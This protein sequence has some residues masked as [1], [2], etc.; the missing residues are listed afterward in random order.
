MS[1]FST[2]RFKCLSAE[3]VEESLKNEEVPEQE[4]EKDTNKD[5]TIEESVV[6]FLLDALDN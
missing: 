3:Y 5:E 1:I 2:N 6:D 4:E